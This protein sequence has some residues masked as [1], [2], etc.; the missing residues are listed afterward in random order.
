M[1]ERFRY[2]VLVDHKARWRN[3]SACMII[4][5]AWYLISK[6]A[7]VESV[8]AFKVSLGFLIVPVVISTLW[9][10][11]KPQG[12]KSLVEIDL[13]R[14]SLLTGLAASIVL[15]ALLGFGTPALEAAI[16]D[17]RLRELLEGEPTQDKIEEATQI[18]S[19]ANDK[20]LR[21][22]PQLISQ[23]GQKL[24]ESSSKPHL[25]DS[26]LTAASAFASY[27]SSLSPL[28]PTS[29][30]PSEIVGT[31]VFQ[32]G[33]EPLAGESPIVSG[34]PWVKGGPS[35]FGCS[36]AFVHILEPL[37]TQ[38]QLPLDGLYAR[39]ITF[40]GGTFLYDG[41]QLKLESVLFIDSRIQVPLT[42]TGNQ[43]VQR[44]IGAMLTGQPINLDLSTS[45]PM[46][47]REVPFREKSPS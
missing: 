45:S 18:V 30:A 29:A 40:V 3:D 38:G 15:L 39:S 47:P 22:S 34:V 2:Y 33:A 1:I 4:S 37:S 9:Y 13:P 31:I 27:R 5:I 11:L 17:K 46:S 14:R 25:R 10:C 6:A 32:C 20:K 16:I 26:A 24:L 42:N 35:G 28:P 19:E 7:G 36:R 12:V 23:L 44:L 21:A 41:G 8:R 43:N